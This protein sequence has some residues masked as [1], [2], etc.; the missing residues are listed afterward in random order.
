M[1]R[2]PE[3]VSEQYQRFA[4]A[5]V[6]S[7]NATE[8]AIMAGYSPSSARTQ[9][10]K[11]VARPDVQAE[12]EAVRQRSVA[13]S[14]WDAGRV[15]NELVATAREARDG[16][17]YQAAVRAYE[18]IGKHV[19][20]W[21]RV[22]DNIDARQINIDLS[23]VTTEELRAMLSGAASTAGLLGAPTVIDGPESP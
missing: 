17:Q 13:A 1:S 18:L 19:G 15:I 12:I 6:A 14:A 4:T 9:G 23:E 20:M 3:L 5:Y 8:S 16:Q 22:A 2:K 21:P 11:L 10:S 7:G